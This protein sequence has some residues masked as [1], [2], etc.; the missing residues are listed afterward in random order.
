MELNGYYSNEELNTMMEKG[1]INSLDYVKHLSEDLAEDFKD[2]CKKNNFEE[3][4][5]S[6]TSFLESLV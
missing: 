4:V 5:E 6:A 3:T 1:E 2:Y